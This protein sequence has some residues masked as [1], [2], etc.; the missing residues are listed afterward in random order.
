[1]LNKTVMFY[2][3]DV[4]L[5]LIPAG[6]KVPATAEISFPVD[7]SMAQGFQF[8]VGQRAEKPTDI[9]FQ[10]LGEINIDDFPAS[11]STLD[12]LISVHVTDEKI[13]MMQAIFS[14]GGQPL[15]RPMEFG[16]YFVD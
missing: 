12:L 10:A 15:G 2:T 3:A 6:E 4:Y 16:R 5:D 9:D 13:L 14:R 11:D 7:E 1:M 8:G